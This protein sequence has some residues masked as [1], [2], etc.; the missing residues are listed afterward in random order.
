ML[1]AVPVEA[2]AFEDSRRSFDI[3][4]QEL[5][6]ALRRVAAEADVELLASTEDLSGLRSAPLRGSYSIREAIEQLL[7][8]SPLDAAFD[9][10]SIIITRKSRPASAKASTEPAIIVTGSRIAGAPPAAPVVTI[11]DDDIRKGGFADLG[12]VA[13]SLPQ[14]FGGGQNPGIGNSQGTGLENANVNGASTFNLRGIGPN[15]TLTLLNGNR[16]SST[17]ISSTIDVSAIPVSAVER[18]EVVAD[19]A[20]AIYGADA[21]AGVVNI[22]LRKDYEGLETSARIGGSTDGGNFQQQY[23]LLGGT[24]W[25]GGGLL[26]AYDYFSNG[27]I[28]AGDRSYA[29]ANNPETILYPATR[30]HNFLVSGHHELGGG[31][32]VNADLIY[33]RGHIDRAVGLTLDR[34]VTFRGNETRT[35]FEAFGV[36]PGIEA[37]LGGGWTARAAGFY[38]TDR[39]FG[40]TQNYADGA[41]TTRGVRHFNNRTLAV[42]GGLQGPLFTLPA[43][44]MRLA[45]GGGVRSN[46]IAVELQGDTLEPRRTNRFAYAEVFLPLA[47]PAQDIGAAHRASVTAALRYEDYSDSGSIVTPKLGLVYAPA[48][49]LSFGLSWGRS[50]KLPALYQQY[51]GYSA[52]LLPVTGYGDRFP[53]GSTYLVLVGPD[54]DVGPER[55]ENWT[56]SATI[57]PVPRFETTLSLYRIDYRGRVAAPFPSILGALTNPLYADF[58]TF[59]PS[60]ALL[61]ASIAGAPE[62]LQNATTGAF[63]PANVAALLDGRDRNIL[64]QRYQGIDLSLRYRA[65]LAGDRSLELSAAGSW[66]DSRQR[67]LPGLPR[68]DLSGTIF[69]PSHFRGRANASFGSEQA[70]V[71]AFVNYSSSVMDRRRAIPVELGAYATFDLT[72]Q[73]KLG[74]IAEISLNA[75]N[76]FDAKPEAIAVSSPFDTPFDTTNYSAVGRLLGVTIRRNW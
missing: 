66:L 76:I 9:G 41:P 19:G 42:E 16:L 37:E 7:R 71:A 29:D 63:D 34:P 33:K 56:L 57:K 38:G 69:N 6:E 17:G 68:T 1:A 44:D 61:G 50:F 32:T 13:R 36:A 62:G 5:G 10:T 11:T 27:V 15:A 67:V 45:V 14:N 46:R 52:I 31:I 40:V 23:G 75:L 24:R 3:A 20:S 65:P 43:G 30:R 21:V 64:R 4:A 35:R 2:S 26:A 54:P 72:A 58:V 53:A 70:S 60:A 48:E 39:T 8:G 51:S 47:S 73:F 25:T 59:N 28:R 74:D 55:S 49:A 18:I 22:L 12:E